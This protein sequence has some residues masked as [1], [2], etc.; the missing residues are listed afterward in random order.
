MPNLLAL[1]T[2][3]I[4]LDANNLLLLA[5]PDTH[6]LLPETVLDETDSKKS[7]HSEL[8]FQAR[9]AGRILSQCTQTSSTVHAP[10]TITILE[11]PSGA[12]FHVVSSS[13]YPQSFDRDPSITNDRKIL[14]IVTLYKRIY[15]G[16]VSFMSN[17]VMCRIRAASLGITTIDLK[18]VSD[19]ELQLTRKVEVP[20][21]AF[22]NLHNTPITEVVPDHL[23][24]TYNYIFIDAESGQSKLA[25][26]QPSGLIDILGKATEAELRRQDVPPQNA[27][28]LFLSRAIQ[29]PAI[30]VVIA[31][32]RA[33]SGKSITALSNAIAL[34]KRG[35]YSS[36]YYIR[37]SVPDLEKAEAIGFLPGSNEKIAP[38]MTPLEDTL[39]FIVRSSLK[40][41][42]ARGADLEEL[43]AQKT[44]KLIK[45]CNIQGIITLGM[46]GRTIDDAVIII[47][48]AQ[49][50][51]QSATVK[52]L[53]RFG[54]N[55]KIIITGSNRQ[56]DH[57]Y[58][59]KYTNGL[60]VLLDACRTPNPDIRIHA[61]SLT[62]VLRS[63]L[64]SW[65]E[66]I[67][68]S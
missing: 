21:T 18:S 56:I 31:E 58:L 59:T 28:Q 60:S 68:E 12:V 51:S 62:K 37:S 41:S 65:A 50:L 23:P 40:S 24:E 14:E 45:Q 36:I 49:N 35:D 46:R 38:F 55:C 2:N 25:N 42:K 33:G 9:Q 26:V 8:A 32:S 10:L 52:V 5:S 22:S 39:D 57:P 34:V 4:L 20:P 7:G 44:E 66:T 6:I 13:Q 17:D 11:H 1:D 27:G 29:D 64:A 30:N 63:P 19:T 61:V 53:T 54:R 48:E 15:Q 67:F 47:D 43:V 16:E 3:I